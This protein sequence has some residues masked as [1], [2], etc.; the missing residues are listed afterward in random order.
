[1]IHYIEGNQLTKEILK[2][3][4]L[5]VAEFIIQNSQLCEKQHD[6]LKEVEHEYCNSIEVFKIDFEEAQDI[7]VL[8]N[9]S[10]TPTLIFFKDNE[11]IERKIGFTE[12]CSIINIINEFIGEN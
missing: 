3:N 10:S 4:K 9:I 7:K 2:S 5:I 6:I 12:A 8:Y 11:E 1:M